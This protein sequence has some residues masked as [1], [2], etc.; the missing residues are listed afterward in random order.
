MS[1][2][3]DMSQVDR[4]ARDLAVAGVVVKKVAD[5]TVAATAEGVRDDAS[6][7]SPRL[8]GELAASWLVVSDG[9]ARIV[10]SNVRQAF[11]Q[12]FGTSRHGPQPSLFPAAD[13]G[14]KMMVVAIEAAA[15]AIL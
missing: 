7:R 3:V 4:V 2:T 12:E 8:T 13:R 15:G 1:V 9:A 10:T 11:F 6:R 14:A 5:V